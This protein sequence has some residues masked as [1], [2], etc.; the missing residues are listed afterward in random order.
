MNSILQKQTHPDLETW[1]ELLN[2]AMA[3]IAVVERTSGTARQIR[4]GGG[5]V[6][7]ALWGHRYSKD[8]DLF[9]RD[10]QII[11]FLRP[12]LNDEVGAILGSDYVEGTNAIK[13]RLKSGS[14]DVVAAADV[15]PDS[16]PTVEIYRG[17]TIEIED[18]AEILAKKLFHRGDR[19]TVRDYVD[20]IRG[21]KEIE[22]LPQRLCGP[23]KG[24]ISRATE[25]L[26]QIP[27]DRFK[28]D[29]DAIRFIGKFPDAKDVR[30]EALE[31][32]ESIAAPSG[33]DGGQAQKAAWLANQ[34][35]R[36]R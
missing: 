8:V 15:L 17:R 4:L 25:V 34:R 10:P 7:S 21:M 24:K 32:M 36:G 6:L 9:T 5:T 20:L 28:A 27:A 13:F 11:G 35:G 3:A 16:S 14:I 29:L 1:R 31:A 19:G 30:M 2:K 18:P 26:R 23:L 33:G 12:W 22:G